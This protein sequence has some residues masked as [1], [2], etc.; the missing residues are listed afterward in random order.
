MVKKDLYL[1]V[2]DFIKTNHKLPK[3]ISKQKAYYYTQKL[4]KEGFIEKV[5][6]GVWSTTSKDFSTKVVDVT[7]RKTRGHGFVFKVSFPSIQGWEKRE[8]QFKKLSLHYD[9]LKNGQRMF[10]LGKKVNI[11]HN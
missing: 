6:T 5:S 9:P 3:D 4:S 7:Q 8:N 2:Y 11:Y 10:V 1:Y